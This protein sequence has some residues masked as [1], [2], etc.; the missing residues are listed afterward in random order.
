MDA[1]TGF[2]PKFS[3]KIELSN[4]LKDSDAKLN[5]NLQGLERISVLHQLLENIAVH[6]NTHI[7]YARAIIEE[8]KKM[9]AEEF[10]NKFACNCDESEHGEI[11]KIDCIEECTLMA[12]RQ[13]RILEYK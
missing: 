11:C 9:S 5:E 8:M 3:T 1:S 2:D 13:L 4:Q 12:D 7:G 6:T 10:F